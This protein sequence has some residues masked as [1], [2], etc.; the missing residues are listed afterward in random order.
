MEWILPSETWLYFSWT[1][2]SVLL[3]WWIFFTGINNQEAPKET[4]ERKRIA[5]EMRITWTLS[6]IALLIALSSLVIAWLAYLKS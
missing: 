5:R 1:R 2:G 3:D 6:I 4:E